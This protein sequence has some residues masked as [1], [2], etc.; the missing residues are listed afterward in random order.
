MAIHCGETD[1]DAAER[2]DRLL[3]PK[4]MSGLVGDWEILINRVVPSDSD[5]GDK[6]AHPTAELFARRPL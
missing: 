2:P 6:H 1:E 5:P 3:G 4:E